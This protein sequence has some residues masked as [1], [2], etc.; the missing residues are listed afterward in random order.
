MGIIDYRSL[1]TSHY[2]A[3]FCKGIDGN[4]KVKGRK[5]RIVVDTLGLPRAV[6]IHEANIHDSK[7]APNVIEKREHKFPRLTKIL[8]DGGYHGTL[9]DWVSEKFGWTVELV[10]R[11]DEC[12]TS[13][14]YFPNDG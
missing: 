13:S 6:A 8:A 9:G 4:K 11:P 1:K 7:G 10:P 3:P 12:P 2:A 5:E 14:P